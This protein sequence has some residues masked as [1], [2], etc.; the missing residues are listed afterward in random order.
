M[1]QDIRFAV[2]RLS[3][4]PGYTLL[5]VVTLA[6][7]IG[8]ATAVFSVVDQ[9]I[10]R[11]PPF[12]HADRLVDVLHVN[13]RRRGGGNQLY[14]QKIVGWQQQ[15]SLFDRFEAYAPA[16]MDLTGGTEA[17]RVRGQHVS[18]G[19]FSML[20]VQPRIGRAFQKGDGA[21]G[22]ERVVILSHSLWQ[23]RFGGDAGA[24]GQRITL[25]DEDY[26]I[27]GVMPRRFLLQSETDAFWLPF[28]VDARI[29]DVSIRSFYGV[30][31]LAR[32]VSH[33][34]AQRLADE[35]A[36]RLQAESPLP[37][38]WGLGLSRKEIARV[39]QTTRT[40]L[41]VLLGAVGF[42]LLIACANVAN[43]FLSHAPARQREM[44][45]QSAL[46]AS[47]FMLARAV[48]VEST[49]VALVGGALGILLAR[50]GVAAVL[51]AAPA[52]LFVRVT[53]T[54]ELDGRVL[55]VATVMILASGILFGLVPALRG[56]RP[57]LERSL[58]GGSH[59][60]GR[61]AYGRVPGILVVAEVTFAVILLVGAALMARTLGNLY[62]LDPGFDAEGV[63]SMNVDL[64]SDRYPTQ[65]ARMEF[66]ETLA[67]RLRAAGSISDVAVGQGI[68]PSLGGITFGSPEV[69][70]RAAAA[71][72][73]MILPNGVVSKD[74]FQTLR[75]PLLAGRNFTATDDQYTVIVSK[76][77]ADTLWPDGNS[78][79]SRFRLDPKWPWLTVAGV[80][81][82]VQTGTG[83]ERTTMQMYYPWVVLPTGPRAA[84]GTNVTP[85][86][87]PS[88][89]RRSYDYR[90]LVAR[91]VDP[92]A[93]IGSI[94]Q[95][96]AA[97]DR[98]QPVHR[99][100]L[101][102]ASY[103][104][105]FA[106]ERFVLQLMGSFA[107]VALMLTAAGIFGVLS[108]AVAQRTR[109][110]GIRMALG[111]RPADVM[112]LVISRGMLLTC[113]GAALG[114]AG[115]LALVRTVQALLYDVKPTDPVSFAA[116]IVLLL[117]VG[118]LA[119]WLP[120]RNAMKID[121]SVTLRVD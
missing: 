20:G 86:G 45:I 2:R 76:T 32:G 75:I 11:P 92:S 35:I 109:E 73:E 71:H 60:S 38:S 62:A 16:Q 23:R 39:D 31:R 53:S 107:L 49:L 13:R 14:A 95:Q 54:I 52:Q 120:T 100:A 10:L 99:V 29:T 97:M 36:D 17:E 25:N 55:L 83:N 68:P 64:P 103:A 3:A 70:G 63:V 9:T 98:N 12:L 22:S 111:A 117:V 118:L 108:Q 41:Y 1:L 65:A 19:L 114:V 33:A 79:G 43:L 18:L 91:A 47:R 51:A 58:R 84:P 87:P 96:I 42:V 101:A 116:V 93:A 15:P 4:R 59:A 44:A 89:P 67:A 66:F 21:I 113:L 6:L 27:V 104:E 57:N 34:D 28:D 106:K 90:I 121:P 82:N 8:A 112:K 69:E 80:V 81:G 48:L 105:M 26:T 115:A 102:T 94:K 46:G 78:I 77:L 24:L 85:V 72:G 88:R 37:N 50:W 5:I 40:A 61:S 56:S 30:G 110:I 74:Y 119:C 7:G